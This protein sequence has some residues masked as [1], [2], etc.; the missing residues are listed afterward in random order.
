MAEAIAH[1][2]APDAIEALSAGL[3]PIGFVA[4]LTKQ[5]LMR[6]KYWVEGLESKSI[7]R[8]VWEQA[9]IV[10][11]MSGR[12]REQA[13][14]EYSKVEDWEIED[15]FGGDPDLY[16]QVFEKIRLR[17]AELARECGRKNAAVRSAERRAHARL[18]PRSPIFINVNG[19]Y[20]GIAFNIS[21]DGLALSPGMALPDGPLHNM[22]IQFPR[23]Q[24]W[25]EISGRIAWKSKSN[26]T[27]GIRFDG[28]T[29][30]ACQQIRNWIS[31]HASAG[32]FQEQTDRICEE[33]NPR[34]E[35]PNAPRPGNMTRG[36]STFGEVI[37][38]HGEASLF[39]PDTRTFKKVFQ[40]RSKLARDQSY[41][42]VPRPRGWTFFTLL[43]WGTFAS[44]GVLIG[45]TSLFFGWMSMRRDVR[46][47]MSAA[48]KQETE[49]SSKA[50]RGATPPPASGIPRAPN[51]SEEK[52]DLQPR[53][54]ETL[55]AEEHES[56]PN[57]TLKNPDKQ[58]RGV[59]RPSAN[60]ILKIA[61]HPVNGVLARGEATNEPSRAAAAMNIP[62]VEKVQPQPVGNLPATRPQLEAAIAPPVILASNPP[63][64]DLK[65]IEI[66]MPSAKQPALP[67]KITGAVAILADPYPSLRIPDGGISKKQR[68][69]TSLQLGHLLSRVEPIYPEEAK[70]QGIEG[71]VKLH[72]II[73]RQGSVENLESVDGS[74]VLVAAAVNAVRQWRYTETLVAGQSVETEE[75]IAITFR[76][77]NPTP[78]TN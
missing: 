23:Y 52:M 54:V 63:P 47:E 11:N 53:S 37:Q 42:G 75:D 73:G 9:D 48:V 33:R 36:S 34:V 78:P 4:P 8:E 31:S 70:Q 27:L 57:T 12:P 25:I 10:I 44:T 72:A 67:A 62:P 40:S 29:E 76:L 3:T 71:T 69:A 13:F 51:P 7:S 17:I 55:V 22:R 41:P 1:L 64:V 68:Q 24:P 14:R 26:K 38:E 50:V 58:V 45:L 30:E 28:L 18:Y 15:P 56:I 49:V 46:R 35:I 61:S 6:N 20:G 77:S 66:S 60:A 65:K 2:D 43:R 5:T 19:A 74:A 16:Q 59:E 32:D 21:E 39:S